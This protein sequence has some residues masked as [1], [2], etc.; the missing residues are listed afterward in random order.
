MRR[1]PVT[2]TVRTVTA[3]TPGSA[4]ESGIAQNRSTYRY[5]RSNPHISG[6]SALE[7]VRG[8]LLGF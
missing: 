3:S 6:K 1:D 5:K 7:R 2:S 4:G 8:K